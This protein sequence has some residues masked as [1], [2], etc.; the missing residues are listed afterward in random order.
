[1]REAFADTYVAR[2][3]ALTEVAESIAAALETAETPAS[4]AVTLFDQG[5]GT[6]EVSAHYPDEPN[7]NDLIALLGDARYA[8]EIGT[9]RIERLLPQDWVSRSESLRGPV[10]AGRFLVH[11][12]HDR[13]K[14]PQGRFT[15]EIDAGLA[16]G[17]AHHATTRG[18]LI[19]LDRLLKRGRPNRVLDVGTGTGILAIAAAKALGRPVIASDVDPTAVAVAAE[20]AAGNGVRARVLVVKAKGLAHPALRR[21]K[22]DLLFAN[23]LLRPLLQL[24]PDFA[25]AVWPGGVCVLSGILDTQARQVEAHFRALG[26]RLD[27]RILLGGWT[28][29]LLRRGSRSKAPAD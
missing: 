12:R 23:L 15:F 5:D 27:S 9:L 7:R 1:M 4:M 20:N 11:G 22:A 2:I 6:V 17:T 18:C 14:V 8:N 19:A 3:E 29:L 26:F 10:R 16:F 24:A 25:R 28:T 13:G 21:A